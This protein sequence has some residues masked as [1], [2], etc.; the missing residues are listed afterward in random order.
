[1]VFNLDKLLDILLK[2]G[3]GLF[4]FTAILFIIYKYMNRKKFKYDAEVYEKD[5][6]GNISA[7]LDKFGI[8]V[9]K[10]T[11]KEMGWLKNSKDGIGLDKFSYQTIRDKKGYHKLV[12]L[13]KLG[14]GNYAY[15]KPMI[16]TDKC[17]LI[18]SRADVDWAINA[19][20]KWTKVLQYSD[21][22]KQIMSYML[23]G[24][25]IVIV[26]VV[27]VLLIRNIPTLAKTMQTAAV[28]MKESSAS[29]LQAAKVS[30]GVI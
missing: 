4:I 30:K 24:L 12:R 22:M 21:K 18:A 23:I 1:M 9:D 8:S 26:F 17:E 15:L 3:L 16:T 10:K 14:E 19:Y 28:A 29:I 6:S 5:N 13:V 7:H 27:L 2:G 11:N 20:V 25:A